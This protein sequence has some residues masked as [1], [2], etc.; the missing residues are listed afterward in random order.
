[1]SKKISAI[2][3]ASSLVV[4]ASLLPACSNTNQ[5]TRANIEGE[6]IATVNG[7][8]ITKPMFDTYAKQRM[9]QSRD[10]NQEIT[11]EQR[12]GMIKELI[13]RELLFQDATRK[14][15]EK[16]QDIAVEILNYRLNSVASA[17]VK[18][19]LATTPPTEE[20][21]KAEYNKQMIGGSLKEFKARHILVESE[22]EARKIIKQ[23]K[24]GAKF[25]ELA[26]EKSTGPSSS[27][28]GD[29]GWFSA[30]QM[31]TPFAE[32]AAQLQKG[33]YSKDPVKTQFGWHV[34]LL[35][36]MR[37]IA[38][39]E[40]EEIKGQLRMTVQSSMMENYIERLR[41]SAKIEKK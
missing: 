39:P 10:M 8:K 36:D 20:D 25:D 22:S 1:M 35:E 27:H 19:Y 21:L 17:M 12:E 2:K 28:G 30:D 3:L 5:Q 6:L 14:G 31:V 13:D 37:N 18:D 4:M 40:F 38:A 15:L 23:L 24:D 11:D 16:R 41:A 7:T 26:K 29:L 33:E 34:I 32:A 9:S